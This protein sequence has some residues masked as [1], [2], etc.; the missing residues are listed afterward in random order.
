MNGL[1]PE[2]V[3]GDLLNEK[4]S[5]SI[6]EAFSELKEKTEEI[7]AQIGKLSYSGEI[8]FHP[9]KETIW[10]RLNAAYEN[11]PLVG[12]WRHCLVSEESQLIALVLPGLRENNH[13]C[14]LQL[15]KAFL[16]AGFLMQHKATSQ[17]TVKIFWFTKGSLNCFTPHHSEAT[18]FLADLVSE[19]IMDSDY[20]LLPIKAIF[21]NMPVINDNDGYA[22]LLEKEINKSSTNSPSIAEKLPVS[23]KLSNLQVPSDARDKV[24]RRFWKNI[25]ESLKLHFT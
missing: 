14:F 12:K 18:K 25:P 5:V 9:G 2:A 6:E 8:N 3:F 1:F 10:N 11:I 17:F 4:Y 16:F 19:Y 13:C 21:N 22:D 15:L 7:T 23:L 24:L 20:D